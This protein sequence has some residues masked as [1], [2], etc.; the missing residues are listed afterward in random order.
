VSAYVRAIE[1]RKRAVLEQF[2]DA[3]HTQRALNQPTH[4]VHVKYHRINKYLNTH[5]GQHR[6]DRA[7]D[8]MGRALCHWIMVWPQSSQVVGGGWAKKK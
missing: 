2:M 6:E 7:P 5:F 3:H 4:L 1:G 8:Q